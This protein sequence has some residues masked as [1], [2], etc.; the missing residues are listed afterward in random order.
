LHR[1]FVAGPLKSTTLNTLFPHSP[2][3]EDNWSPSTSVTLDRRIVAHD[4]VRPVGAHGLHPHRGPA[5]ADFEAR[6]S[7][8]GCTV[9]CAA[10][11]AEV[12]KLLTE[13][14]RFDAALIDLSLPNLPEVA[15]LARPVP[16]V[17]L[18][19]I[20]GDVTA[21]TP[22]GPCARFLRKPIKQREVLASIVSVTGGADAAP[23]TAA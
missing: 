16:I 23:S 20:R 11:G 14:S 6:D 12:E 13:A 18:R 15:E 22:C 19:S 7:R 1:S 17:G 5:I 9:R 3:S 4:R 21:A 8:K 10:S 2:A